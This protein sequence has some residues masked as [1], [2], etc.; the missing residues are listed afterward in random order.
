MYKLTSENLGRLLNE[1]YEHLDIP[2]EKLLLAK[3]KYIHLGQ[4]LNQDAATNFRN[5]SELYLQ[6]SALLGTGILPIKF[7]DEFDL[8]LVYRRDIQ[9]ESIT[10]TDLKRQVGDQLGRYVSYLCNSKDLDI[11]TLEEGKRCWTLRYSGRFHMDI[12]PALPDPASESLIKPTDG[13]LITDKD[14]SKWQFSNPKGYHVWFRQ[15]MIHTLNEKRLALAKSANVSVEAIPEDT[16]KTTLQKAIQILKRHRDSCF[17]GNPKNKPASTII[18]T[19]AALAYNNNDDIVNDLHH[20][21]N[22][23]AKHIETRGNELWVP[24]PINHK[25]N[26]ADR[27]RDNKEKAD[28]FFRWLDLA[29]DTFS[30]L[31]IENNENSIANLLSKSFRI[32]GAEKI[33]K[34]AYTRAALAAAAS[35]VTKKTDPWSRS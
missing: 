16:V 29:H 20:I 13:I 25:E 26:F 22:N 19:L 15:S 28:E 27:W 32:E 18:N 4:W 35:T 6:G 7:G 33:A 2:P 12:L 14:L 17:E 9:K 8:D 31:A 3:E 30:M 24:N 23:M 10:Q 5:S 34:S 21:V 11:P 1:L